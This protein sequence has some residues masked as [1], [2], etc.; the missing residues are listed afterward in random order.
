MN[1]QHP[2]FTRRALEIAQAK[3]QEMRAE[4]DQVGLVCAEPEISQY[5][6]EFP[7]EL[8]LKFY[9]AGNLEDVLEYLIIRNGVQLVTEEKIAT[10][11]DMDLKEIIAE[12]RTKKKR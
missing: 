8:T 7:V 2:E 1:D 11:L 4:L 5:G 12:E 3:L 10:D 6:C 9:C